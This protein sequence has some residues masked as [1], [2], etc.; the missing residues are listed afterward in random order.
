MPKNRLIYYGLLILA[1]SVLLWIG[2]ELTKRI[3]WI[4]PYTAAVGVGVA[5]L[6]M[7]QE[8]WRI[9]RE[10]RLPPD[11]QHLNASPPNPS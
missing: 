1:A 7:I 5:L 4:L 10:A 3:A 11:S 9:R 8:S 6:G 2:A